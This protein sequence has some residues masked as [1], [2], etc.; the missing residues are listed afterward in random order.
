MN[1]NTLNDG[2]KK[3]DHTAILFTQNNCNWCDK[4]KESIKDLDISAKEVKLTSDLVKKF[5][6]IVSPTLVIS[7]DMKNEVLHVPGYKTASELKQ[8]IDKF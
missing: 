3:G 2:I 1:V 4:M 5:D 6:I 8:I 7:S